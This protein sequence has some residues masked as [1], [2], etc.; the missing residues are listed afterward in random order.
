MINKLIFFLFWGVVE[1]LARFYEILGSTLEYL[2]VPWRY[3]G[4]TLEVLWIFR[5]S[6]SGSVFAIGHFVCQQ[7]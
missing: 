1:E 7:K 4:G 5:F 3:L 2:E 6:G